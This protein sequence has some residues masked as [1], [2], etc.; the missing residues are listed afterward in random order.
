MDSFA[1]V[2][3]LDH[4][5]ICSRLTAE[6]EVY[7]ASDN[8]GSGYFSFAEVIVLNEGSKAFNEE[9]SRSGNLQRAQTICQIVE[10]Q[11]K[12]LANK[13]RHEFE[14]QRNSASV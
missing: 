10:E 2:P 13:V 14:R 5:D 7:W 8:D 12:K 1:L 6:A 3:Q 4:D 11:V 9:M